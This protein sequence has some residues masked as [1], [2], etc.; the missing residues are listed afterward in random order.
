MVFLIWFTSDLHLGH[1]NIIK[2]SSRPFANIDEMDNRL[3]ANWNSVIN[4]SDDIYIV[5]DFSLKSVNDVENYLRRLN[6][7][8]HLIRGNHDRVGA[9]PYNVPAGLEWVRDYHELKVE[10]VRFILFHYPIFEWNAVYRGS[11]HLYGHVHR[12]V[13]YSGWHRDKAWHSVNVGVDV[14]NYYPISVKQIFSVAR[15][16]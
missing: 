15:T 3:V 5:G 2:L 11:I 1:V 13:G 6:G 10:G 4:K 8:K 12:D 7:K 9:Y 16:V 14:N